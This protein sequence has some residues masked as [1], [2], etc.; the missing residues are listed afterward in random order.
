MAYSS[1]AL[2]MAVPLGLESAERLWFY[3]SSDSH[4]DITSTGYFAGA[5]FGSKMRSSDAGREKGM[6]LRDVLLSVE[7]S[8]G[9][10]PG[11]ASLHSVVASTANQA[12]TAA[13]TGY[14]TEYNVSV[15]SAAT[16]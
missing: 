14:M 12:S 1:S 3:R 8:A 5:G 16:T 15:S 4:E 13:S 6:K 2:R 9:V 11:R 7:S 10:N